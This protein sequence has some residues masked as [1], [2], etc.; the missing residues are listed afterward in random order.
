MNKP[1]EAP[2]SNNDREFRRIVQSYVALESVMKRLIS[3]YF[4]N[5]RKSDLFTKAV[6]ENLTFKR[7][8]DIFKNINASEEIL[9]D[10]EIQQLA[11]L[12][13][14]RNSIVHASRIDEDYYSLLGRG[15]S[16][17]IT[18]KELRELYFSYYSAIG[19]KLE[20]KIESFLTKE[21]N[22]EREKILRD[23][24]IVTVDVR[25][26]KGWF[27]DI[28]DLTA[29]D[30]HGDYVSLDYPDYQ[31]PVE[32]YEPIIEEKVREYLSKNY[33]VRADNYTVEVYLSWKEHESD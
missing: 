2:E 30:T 18:F 27:T 16:T 6:L 19:R 29:E 15:K 4:T 1:T 31:Y 28:Y 9:T 24:A 33:D 22:E 14:I 8:Y 5:D 21:R 10:T 20:A 3:H 25:N 12:S 32:D 23:L 17:P 7:N 26:Y 13:R 11:L